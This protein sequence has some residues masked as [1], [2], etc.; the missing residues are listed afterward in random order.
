MGGDLFSLLTHMTQHPIG[1]FISPDRML[2]SFSLR[3]Q[4]LSLLPRL[5]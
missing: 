3:G 2:V 4:A 5:D 1:D